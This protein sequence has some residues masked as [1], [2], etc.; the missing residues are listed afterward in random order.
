MQAYIAG[1]LAARAA[2]ALDDAEI[3]RLQQIQARLEAA[4]RDAM[5]GHIRHIGRLLIDH[6]KSHDVLNHPTTPR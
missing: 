1:E 5:A 6:L 4:A 2:N 3:A